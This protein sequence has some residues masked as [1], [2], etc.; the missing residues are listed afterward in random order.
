MPGLVPG[1]H[2]FA[3]HDAR[4]TCKKT[5]KA[6]TN[7]AMTN[8][9]IASG[10]AASYLAKMP[11]TAADRPTLPGGRGTLGPRVAGAAGFFGAL[12]KLKKSRSAGAPD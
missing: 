10:Q 7:P 9:E 2:V 3:A 5:W 6:G 4:K 1:I 12:P 8:H 11:G